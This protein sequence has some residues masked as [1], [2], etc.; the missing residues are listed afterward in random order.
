MCQVLKR[1]HCKSCTNIVN[2]TV[3]LFCSCSAL[4]WMLIDPPFKSDFLISLPMPWRK[5]D[6]RSVHATTYTSSKT[7]IGIFVGRH[8]TWL[9]AIPCPPCFV[10][11]HSL[12][13]QIWTKH[14]RK[15]RITMG[16]HDDIASEQNA[17]TYRLYRSA[18]KETQVT[19]EWL[20]QISSS[21]TCNQLK[22][23]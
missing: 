21:K 6:E 14:K 5:I 1:K 16:K 2:Q 19:V 17:L 12:H 18:C 23:N 15:L 9:I 22:Y 13:N 4:H 8:W 20:A 10:L 7:N 11:V 3:I